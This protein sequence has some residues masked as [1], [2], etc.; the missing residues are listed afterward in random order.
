M[1]TAELLKEL[2]GLSKEELK[3]RLTQTHE[4]LAN[5]NFQK[6]TQPLTNPIIL[7]KL[8]RTISRI[9]TVLNAN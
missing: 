2:R 8:R 3:T 9:E 5:L 1:K 4:E 6:A 7:R